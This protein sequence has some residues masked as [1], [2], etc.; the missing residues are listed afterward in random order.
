MKCSLEK[1][2]VLLVNTL[3]HKVKV[4]VFCHVQ[5]VDRLQLLVTRLT[6]IRVQSRSNRTFR[7]GNETSVLVVID[8]LWFWQSSSVLKLFLTFFRDDWKRAVSSESRKMSLFL[9][10]C[11][12][13]EQQE[14]D[15]CLFLLLLITWRAFSGRLKSIGSKSWV[16]RV[17]ARSNKAFVQQ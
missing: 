7:A 16:T 3:E 6:E 13:T 15:D 2:L 9:C 5:K 12:Q 8:E 10:G 4:S 17:A 11:V 1:T 14:E